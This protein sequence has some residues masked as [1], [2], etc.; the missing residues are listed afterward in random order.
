MLSITSQLRD[1][2]CST[3]TCQASILKFASI[4]VTTSVSCSTTARLAMVQLV[5]AGV[6]TVEVLVFK[7]QLLLALFPNLLALA[8]T[9]HHWDAAHVPL[10][11]LVLGAVKAQTALASTPPILLAVILPQ[12][13][14]R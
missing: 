4:D 2:L 14:Q 6:K 13:E 5:V 12:M 7:T 10:K 1:N 3:P 11:A 9:T 8:A